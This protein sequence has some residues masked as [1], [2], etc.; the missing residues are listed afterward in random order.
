MKRILIAYFS[1][2]HH[3][4]QMAKYVAE[5]VRIGGCDAEII[6]ISKLKN[7]KELQ[8]YDGYIFGCPT[9]HKDM[10][11]NMKRFLFLAHDADLSNKAGGAFGS[12]THSGEAPGYIFDTMEHA[13]H[14]KMTS[15]GAFKLKEDEIEVNMTA[16]QDY[17][18]SISDLLA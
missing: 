2:K 7:K 8:G 17:G 14:M 4:E 10:T 13:L 18:K 16:C 11:E 1:L 6:P 15:L 12:S 5:G 3:T 9:Y